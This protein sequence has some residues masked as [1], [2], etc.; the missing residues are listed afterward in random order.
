MI[1]YHSRKLKSSTKFYFSRCIMMI[2]ELNR[3][4]EKRRANMR[5][6][7]F[8]HMEQG[9][10]DTT[11]ASPPSHSPGDTPKDGNAI[12]K[13]K[14]SSSF[15]CESCHWHPCLK[16][17]FSYFRLIHDQKTATRSLSRDC[18]LFLHCRKRLSFCWFCKKKQLL[19]TIA[20]LEY[21]LRRQSRFFKCETNVL[22][23]RKNM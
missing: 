10:P 12:S 9:Y 8:T 7:Q 6:D 1:V 13:N 5:R 4:D 17:Q 3:N 18:R 19:R 15:S 20:N 11:P 16:W 2:K 23:N 21:N 14:Q 22:L